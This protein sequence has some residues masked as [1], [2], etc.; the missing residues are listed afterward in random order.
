MSRQRTRTS[1]PIHPGHCWWWS[2]RWWHKHFMEEQPLESYNI[3]HNY[4]S[5]N[6]ISILMMIIMVVMMMIHDV[7]S[8]QDISFVV[9][10]VSSSWCSKSK[11]KKEKKRNSTRKKRLD[12][13]VRACSPIHGALEL[14]IGASSHEYGAIT[15][16]HPF[17]VSIQEAIFVQIFNYSG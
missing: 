16:G 11:N 10:I 13:I 8:I 14:V 4:Q 2:S 17:I 3:H 6:P 1:D 7:W 9:F 15:R 5:M 12:F